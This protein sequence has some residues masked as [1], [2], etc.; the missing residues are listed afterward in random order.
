MLALS[1]APQPPPTEKRALAVVIVTWNVRDL[2][3]AALD[4]LYADLQAS[5]LSTE[6]YVVDSA[7]TDGTAQAVAA[8]YPAVR[9]MASAENLG[10]GRANNL[11]LR[12][13]MSVPN[14][15][16]AIY[17]LN[18]DT[19][20][21]P[22]ATQT[23]YDALF[24]G[25]RVGLVGAG[26]RYEDGSFQDSAFAFP[27]LRQL[28]I[29]FFPAPGRWIEGTFNGRYPRALYQNGE[30]FPVDFVLGATMMLRREVIEQTGM[31][32]EQFFM[33]CEEIDW[34][35]RNRRG[36]LVSAVRTVGAPGSSERQEYGSGT[37]AQRR[38]PVDEPPAARPETLSGV[39]TL[40]GARADR[41]RHGAQNP[42]NRRSGAARRLSNGSGLSVAGALMRLAAVILTYNEAENVA[43]CI[44][45]L[46]FADQIVVFDSF[47]SDQTVELASRAGAQVIEHPFADYA[48]QR[49]AAL[50]A[51]RNSADWVLFVDAD[52]RVPPELAD[53]VRQRIEQP[54]FAGF[55]IP[56]DNY[57]FGK[58]TRGA[59][60]YP[61]Y[62]TRLLKLGAAHYDPARQVHELVVLDGAERALD[63]A[64]VH[65]NYRDLRQFVAKQRRYGAY[66]ARVLYEQGI[67]PKP[68]NYALQPIRQFWW[69]FV[70]LKGYG[71]GLHGLRLSALMAWYELKKYLLLR[72]LWRGTKP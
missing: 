52:E 47:S 50:D 27:G 20:T 53:E 2:V 69:R 5:D 13:I 35:W 7:S 40:T 45:T 22:G 9:L 18:P 21:Q 30:P 31:F 65:Y 62:Q 23:L 8:A 37:P 55:R 61:D 26:L 71:D 54:T 24:E 56:R 41:A 33:Y 68:Q 19:I 48:S 4:S 59:G 17:L 25:E 66:D 6:V 29:E 60:W 11:A 42:S 14:P 51:L 63:H 12:Q 1:Q 43:A 72:Q 38:Q 32:D 70:T 34:A 46:R 10:F 39:E 36:G 28:W 67:H 15:P 64:L 49:N 16:P 44:E 58:L 57:I 3:L